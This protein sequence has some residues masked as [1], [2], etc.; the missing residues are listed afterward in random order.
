MK[1]KILCVALAV[2]LVATAIFFAVYQAI[3]HTYDYAKNDMSKFVNLTLDD[4]LAADDKSI[5]HSDFTAGEKE[6]LAVI[7][8]QLSD[9]SK[10]NLELSYVGKIGRFDT[11]AY[12]YYITMD[13]DGVET[14]IS[15]GSNLDPTVAASKLKKV[16][17][18]DNSDLSNL[19]S[20][21]VGTDLSEYSFNAITANK[22]AE[23]PIY[24]NDTIYFNY[25]KLDAENKVVTT[26]TYEHGKASELD[27]KFGEGFGA[28]I[29]ALE[30][31][32]SDKEITTADGTKYVVEILFV[33]R[34][35]VNGGEVQNGDIVYFLYKETGDKSLVTYYATAGVDNA[36]L[37]EDFGAG[38]ADKLFDIEIGR[39]V[40]T[41]VEVPAQEGEGTVKYEVQIDYVYRADLSATAE[42]NI[43]RA[44]DFV[45]FEKTYEE[46]AEDVA[47]IKDEEGNPIELKGKTVTYHVVPLYR[48]DA[49]YDMD[50][51]VENFGYTSTEDMKGTV[52]ANYLDAY[53]AYETA[54][55]AFVAARSAYNS[56]TEAQKE[57]KK[58]ALDKAE[59]TLN[60]AREDFLT[61]NEVE[62]E[63]GE[64]APVKTELDH[65]LEA[66][67]KYLVAFDAYK[68]AEEVLKEA[69]QAA[70]GAEAG[71][72]EESAVADATAKFEAA[73]AAM[74]TAK[75]DMETARAAYATS[76]GIEDATTVTVEGIVI[77]S[78]DAYTHVV[79]QDEKDQEFRE[80]VAK[81]IWTNVVKLVE[82]RGVTYPEKALRVTYEALYDEAEEE[83]YENRDK[84]SKY[85]NLKA[86]LAGEIGTDYKA[87]LEAD[88]KEIVMHNLILYRIV[89]LTG[90]E[91]TEDD[92]YMFEF[93]EMYLG[94]DADA[95]GAATLFDKAMDDL[96]E[97]LYPDIFEEEET[98]EEGDDHD[99]DHE[100]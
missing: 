85:K 48:Y 97:R 60:D 65:Y 5:L 20:S 67:A 33:T 56:A 7:A 51:I 74:E 40:S 29:S 81:L 14:V 80:A 63:E 1:K 96:T 23:N 92:T 54:K 95:M 83:F 62:V 71:S 94:Y 45:T 76:K 53:Y 10:L 49:V 91:L 32:D 52:L 50:A 59:G 13:V 87:Q 41:I 2:L 73:K 89:E 36:K 61:F 42:E 79:A 88:A 9:Y 8:R 98:E 86:Y 15:L 12:V 6:A 58:E 75:A 26:G 22:D 19:F 69:E 31:G 66:N 99:H 84:Y 46:D 72:A 44:E 16:Q 68:D 18:G 3:G 21:L 27:A 70:E 47:E 82:D 55:A 38:F 35:T 28:A 100:H 11:L 78:Y 93:Y 39:E 4:L 90:V 37:D 77:E 25:E 30:I 64:E 57:A 34:D 24:A 17:M 43:T